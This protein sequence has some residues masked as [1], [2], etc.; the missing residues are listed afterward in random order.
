MGWVWVSKSEDGCG[1]SIL[2]SRVYSMNVQDGGHNSGSLSAR[3]DLI[4][5]PRMELRLRNQ[6]Y[7]AAV[8]SKCSVKYDFGLP[9]GRSAIIPSCV[10]AK[11]NEVSLTSQLHT[12]FGGG[13]GGF[14][15]LRLRHCYFETV[16]RRFL[17]W[18]Y[19][20][21]N[22]NLGCLCDESSCLVLLCR[23]RTLPFRV[24]RKCSTRRVSRET[25]LRR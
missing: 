15:R 2:I 5:F 9:L 10:N 25:W 6:I 13:G 21:G 24:L 14:G 3:C 16:I 7:C 1:R 23:Q 17:S 4:F 20:N 19:M 11:A 8:M 22:L 18:F 12:C